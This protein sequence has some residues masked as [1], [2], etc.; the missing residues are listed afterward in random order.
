MIKLKWY[1]RVNRDGFQ[2]LFDKLNQFPAGDDTHSYNESKFLEWEF[3]SLRRCLSD[4]SRISKSLEILNQTISRSPCSPTQGSLF[5]MTA[6]ARP[7]SFPLQSS[8]ELFQAILADDVHAMKKTAL[9]TNS[10]GEASNLDYQVLLP[11]MLR[12]A[13]MHGSMDCIQKLLFELTSPKDVDQA[14]LSDYLHCLVTQIG[15]RNSSEALLKDEQFG[16]H[17]LGENYDRKERPIDLLVSV[18]DWIHPS[19]R[20]ALQR[21][22]S[23]GRQPLHYA[24]QYGL[25]DVCQEIIRRMQQWGLMD[26]SGDAA[27][28]LP[29]GEQMTPLHLAV[30]GGHSAVTEILLGSCHLEGIAD[31]AHNPVFATMLA[32]LVSIALKTKSVKIVELLLSGGAEIN[33]Q[34]NIGETI[35]YIAA[36]CG[37]QDCLKSM[38]EVR[39]DVKT[40]INIS[41]QIY[42][43]TPL[44]I[45][46]IEGHL[47][48]VELLLQAGSRW[49]IVDHLGWTAMDHAAFR[50]HMKIVKTLESLEAL[51]STIPSGTAYVDGDVTGSALRSNTK[52]EQGKAGGILT[53][54]KSK[55]AANLPSSGDTQIFVNLGSFDSA[56]DVSCADLSPDLTHTIHAQHPDTQFSLSICAIGCNEPAHV[57]PLPVLEDLVNKPWRFSVSDASTV[58]LVFKVSRATSDANGKGL[59]VSSGVALIESLRRGFRSGRESLMRDYTI[60]ILAVDTLDFMGTVTFSLVVIKPC[61]HK[62][63]APSSMRSMRKQ[64]GSI[65][66]VGHRGNPVFPDL[67]CGLEY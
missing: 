54:S 2:R 37:S 27:W 9:A 51:K 56:K 5:L 1:G 24:V 67:G 32:T 43:W 3:A 59:V 57:I 14:A 12:C 38:I 4:L 6:C 20:C 15:R 44:F 39:P 36:Q 64:S 45:A 29:D 66:V 17:K 22:D 16:R 33:H 34:N 8:A 62:S 48:I 31:K 42:G 7:H 65:Q 49:D 13:T 58:K 18:L 53:S 47:H 26:P 63:P 61:P 19:Q 35:L 25:I 28:L 41:E 21:Q 46:C 10:Q 23:L 55:G 60:P 50:G 40:L 30:I 11:A 52:M